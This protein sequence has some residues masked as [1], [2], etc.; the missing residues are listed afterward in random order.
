MSIAAREFHA[1]PPFGFGFLQLMTGTPLDYAFLD[2]SVGFQNMIGL[3]RENILGKK[4]SEVFWGKR[5]QFDWTGYFRDAVTSQK[6]QEI[7]RYVEVLGRE[8][9]VMVVPSDGQRFALIVEDVKDHIREN[10]SWNTA[11][12]LLLSAL[13]EQFIETKE[14][15]CRLAIHCHLLGLQ[16]QLS[17]KEMEELSLLAV[18]HDIG[19]IGVNPAILKKPGPLTDK[20]WVEIKRH[21]EIGWRIVKKIPGLETVAYGILYHHE[22]WDGTG[23]PL[24]LKGEQIPLAS[25][26]LSVVDAYD[27]M[28]SDRVYRKGIKMDEAMAELIRNAGKQFDPQVVSIFQK[29]VQY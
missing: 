23:Y 28:I 18:L 13:S 6:I 26:I 15:A 16:F 7:S 5:R 21:P 19:K 12:D 24:G 20:E 4:G 22:R 27:A 11:I 1:F 17:S 3:R 25:R 14:H 2:I 8:C 9:H 10:T 29:I